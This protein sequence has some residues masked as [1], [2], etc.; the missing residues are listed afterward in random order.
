[1]KKRVILL[2]FLA[3]VLLPAAALAEVAEDIT[4]RCLFNNRAFDPYHRDEMRDA[5]YKSYYVGKNLYITAPE[6]ELIGSLELKWR[7]INMPG[8]IIMYMVDGEWVE[9]LRDGPKYAT[10]YIVLPESTS[11][12]RIV[13]Q[14]D[15]LELCNVTV[16]SPGETPDYIQIWRDPPEKVDLML[17]STHPDDEVL[18]FGGLLPYYA[19][20]QGKEVL[21]VNAVYGWYYR[22]LELLDSLWTCGVDIY[23]VMLG[24][25]DVYESITAVHQAWDERNRDPENRIVSIIRQYEPDVVVLHDTNGE[26]GHSAHIYFCR[27]GQQGV[28]RA[29][30]PAQH[31]ESAAEWGVWDVPKTYIHLYPENPL[32]MD[33]NQPL[34]AFGGRT[35]L[36]VAGEGFLCHKSQHER[37]NMERSIAYDN[38]LYG[39]WRTTVGPDVVKTDMFENIPEE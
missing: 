39:L 23:P 26:Y 33:W 25:P 34:S 7:T 24:Y 19:A 29:A 5:H 20:E 27:L 37:W 3:L 36:E 1:M 12:I 35:G 13:A 2:L 8:V 6:G 21:V 11:A 32:K 38:S 28:E 4:D 9:V 16:L 31:P 22:R 15:Q 17:L 18:W 30:D 10:Q 14:T